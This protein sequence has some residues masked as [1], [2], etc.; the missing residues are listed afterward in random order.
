L[1]YYLNPKFQLNSIVVSLAVFTIMG[2]FAAMTA[3]SPQV[4]SETNLDEF[5]ESVQPFLLAYCLKCH[6]P[7]KVKGDM[8]LHTL[9]SDF[10][11]EAASD[12]WERVLEM[13]EDGE[14]PPVGELQPKDSERQQISD[15]ITSKLKERVANLN[16]VPRSTV[17]RRL[18]N[19]EYENTMRDLLGFK[20][21]LIGNLPE[22][23]SQPY[24]FNNTAEFMRLG[25]EQANRY[26]ESA[27][28]AMASAIVDPEMPEVHKTRR[29][30]MPNNVDR[31]LGQDEV[32]VWGNRRNTPAKGMELKSF[33]ETGEYRIRVKAAAILPG[34]VSEMPLR[35]V[36]GFGGLDENQ[37]TH[38]IESVGTIRLSNNPDK[39]KVFEFKGR[40]ENHPVRPGRAHRNKQLPP[41]IAITPQNLYDDGTLNDD[42]DFSRS[43]NIGMPRAVVE[44]I[45]FEAPLT[46]V[47]PPEY[48]RQILFDSPLR[49][50]DPKLYVRKVLQRFMDR[51]YRRPVTGDEVDRFVKIYEIISAEL[52]TFEASIRETLA[53]VLVSPQFLYHTVAN[54]S[55]SPQHA[56]AS[57]LSY[58]LWGS[59]PD[60][61]LLRLAV[62]GKLNDPK[63][64][65]NQ[66]W[67]LLADSRS[68]E[69]V[70]NFTM[71]WLSLQKMKTVPINRDVFPRFLY[72]VPRGERVGTEEPYRPSIR[73]Y[74]IEESVGFVTELVDSNASVLNIVD[75][76][77][78]FINQPLAAHY[79]ILGVQGNHF[80][81]VPVKPEH[82]LGGLFAQG[83]VLIGNGTGTAPH[84]IYRAVWLRE[85]ILGDE[86][87]PPPA[88]VPALSDSAGESAEQALS[89]KDLLA[90]HRKKESCFACHARLDPWGIPFEQYNAIGK[91]QPNVPKE[92]A[93]VS[94]FSSKLHTD[95]QGYE[96]YLQSINL[97]PVEASARLPSGASVDG[98]E[99]LKTYL[100][101]NH[102]DE[103]AENVL[104]RLLTY[105]VG[106]ELNYRD[107][108]QVEQMMKEVK[109]NGYKFR[110]MIVLICQS[111]TFR[112][113]GISDEPEEETK[114]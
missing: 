84:P 48:H 8:V 55:T 72:Y 110:D 91:F 49:E 54:E 43:R 106:R 56:F 38:Q 75:S 13:V 1:A 85:A 3:A 92:G 12:Q 104:R 20:L 28:R 73:D 103:I 34:S 64:I 74:M 30:W 57:R 14:M 23:P 52:E 66:V 96:A 70:R 80:R 42:S 95:M 45:E 102:R 82:R 2:C 86:V 7:E 76:E 63:I 22:D 98:M 61:E 10:A 11:A 101:R 24:R 99:E 90:K 87:A 53:M 37:S 59:M 79:G 9:R 65:E 109:G 15:W 31:G 113:V 62:E 26:L 27:R 69:F 68:H 88:D 97:V 6:G 33:P 17:V 105:G 93:R 60:E 50:T 4:N 5:S 78:V 71:Q 111:E 44:W 58:F 36:M 51:A 41:S 46:G 16:Q 18:T 35:L 112:G 77:F 108:F 29:E 107:R 32:G 39:P 40:I 89:I 81:R 25:S 94:G 47:W 83:S 21:N 100:L 114:E 19:F 67:R